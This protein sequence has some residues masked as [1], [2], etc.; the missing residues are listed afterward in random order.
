MR[1]LTKAL[2][3]ILIFLIVGAWAADVNKIIKKVQ[4][5]YDR[6]D[7]LSA[8][9]T[10]VQTFKITGSISE[11]SGKIFVKNGEKYRFESED[12]VIVTN[13]KTVW[14]YNNISK[15]LIIDNVRKNSGALLPRD[16]LFKYPKQYLATL[17]KTEK[18]DGKTVYVIRLDAKEDT[19]SFLKEIKIWVED[20]NWFIHQIE[21]TDLNGNTTLFRIDKMD[22]KTPLSDSLFEYKPA[23]D[24]EIVDMRKQGSE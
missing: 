23:P 4:K 24:V 18:K 7:R 8:D 10:Q 9:F 15:Q 17:L 2:F 19:H 16:L 20:D 12:Q 5:T 3:T 13:G 22:T 1:I 11:T 14:T 6:M 21:T